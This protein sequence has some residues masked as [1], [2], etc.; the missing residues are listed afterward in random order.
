MQSIILYKYSGV[1]LEVWGQNTCVLALC[2][3]SG[4]LP[5]PI[6]LTQGGGGEV[7]PLTFSASSFCLWIPFL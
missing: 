6:G 3:P 4:D 5:G 2:L 1:G 7:F